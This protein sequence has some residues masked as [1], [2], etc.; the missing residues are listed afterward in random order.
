MNTCG[1]RSGRQ[2]RELCR[3]QN[4]EPRDKVE[5]LTMASSQN[6][7]D[8][9]LAGLQVEEVSSFSTQRLAVT[10]QGAGNHRQTH[11]VHLRVSCQ[12]KPVDGL[13][14]RHFRHGEIELDRFPAPNEQEVWIGDVTISFLFLSVKQ[15]RTKDPSLK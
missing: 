15:L 6:R 3:R 1:S 5:S 4:I 2:Q 13:T 8:L 9:H 10:S 12:N 14:T 7:P 11:D